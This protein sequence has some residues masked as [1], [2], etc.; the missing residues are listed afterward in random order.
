ME[1]RRSGICWDG[2]EVVVNVF[3]LVLG[4]ATARFRAARAK[5]CKLG[6]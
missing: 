5:A 3:L 2:K 4:C 1:R 6:S